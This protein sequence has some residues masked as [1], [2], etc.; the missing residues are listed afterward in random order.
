MVIKSVSWLAVIAILVVGLVQADESAKN[1]DKQSGHRMQAVIAKIDAQQDSINVKTMDKNGQKQEKTLQLAKD[2]KIL[3]ADGHTAKLD[4][5]RPGD[6]VLVTTKDGKVTQLRK[7]AQA[8]ITK[9]DAKAG[10]ITVKMMDKNG[11]SIEKTFKLVEDAEYLDSAGHVAVLDVFRSGDDILLIESEGRLQAM[12]KASGDQSST[13]SK[14][15]SE[16]QG[17]R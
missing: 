15:K 4:D 17:T 12:K 3:G 7:H 13:A 9:V 5:F 1:A 11:K 14:Q 10:T 16:K 8:T 2:A 6:N